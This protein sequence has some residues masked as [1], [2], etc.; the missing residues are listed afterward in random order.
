MF[1]EIKDS[2]SWLE[3]LSDGDSATWSDS[4][5]TAR[6]YASLDA[7]GNVSVRMSPVAASLA[8]VYPTR[9]TS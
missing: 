1:V 7:D 3:R 9:L 6:Q 2:E 5:H 4:H 8:Q